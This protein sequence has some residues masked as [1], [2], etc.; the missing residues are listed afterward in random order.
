MPSGNRC[1]KIVIILTIAS[2]RAETK[3]EHSNLK[4][5]K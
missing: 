4:M 2:K 1:K 5:E 3:L